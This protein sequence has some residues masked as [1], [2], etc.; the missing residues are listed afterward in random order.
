MKE[1]SASDTAIRESAGGESRSGVAALSHSR[2][3]TL[4]GFSEKPIS[5]HGIAPLSE[6]RTSQMPINRKNGPAESFREIFRKPI[7]G[8]SGE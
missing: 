5:A 6:Q 2:A 1:L 3:C 8:F 4:N 7:P